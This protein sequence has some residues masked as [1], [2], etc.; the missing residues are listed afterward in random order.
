MN[1]SVSEKLLYGGM[2]GMAAVAVLVI[3]GIVI[4]CVTGRKIRRKLEE[5]YGKPPVSRK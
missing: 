3:T 4:F 1:L 2:A 5:E